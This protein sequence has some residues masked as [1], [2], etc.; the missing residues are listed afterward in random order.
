MFERRDRFG[1]GIGMTVVRSR[2]SPYARAFASR[3]GRNFSVY[4]RVVKLDV[5]AVVRANVFSLRRVFVPYERIE[6]VFVFERRDRF[7][8]GIRM[9]V[10][11]SRISPYARAF[12]GR[13]GRHF[14]VYF[15]VVKLD[16][17]AVARADVFSLRR[18]FVPY[19]RIEFI[20]V[21]ERR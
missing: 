6:F 10:V 8:L 17:F 3:I 21:S 19:E 2:I 7:R 12:A 20:F 15:R 5:F 4:F 1:L 9:T 13:F 11:G 18:I 16:V 14:A